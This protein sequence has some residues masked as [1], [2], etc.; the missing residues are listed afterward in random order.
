[1]ATAK[2][3]QPN[4]ALAVD[5]EAVRQAAAALRR[6]GLVVFPTETVY[7]LGAN[8]LDPE[9]VERIYRVKGRPATSPLIV[10]VASVEGAREVVAEWPEKAARLAE[11]FWPGPLTLVLPKKPIVA[12]IVT[13][14]LATVGVRMPDHAVA[15]ALIREAGVPVAAPSANRF[16]QLSPTRVSHLPDSVRAAA[17]WVLDAGPAPLG[18]EST[19]VSL[20]AS[21]PQLLRPGMISKAELEAVIGHVELAGRIENAHPAPGMHP[22]HYAP[23]T[24]LILVTEGKLPRSGRG[25]Y[26]WLRQPAP[27]ARLVRMPPEPAAYAALLYATLHELDREGYDWIAV[28]RPPETVEWAA[29][30]DRLQRA[31]A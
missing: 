7:G 19:V 27:A 8:A 14:G 13:A 23:A 9:A 17:D 26:L 10:H 28:E 30:A 21:P 29:I 1:L 25:A 3:K 11:R 12:D 2:T 20:A 15:L 6:G 22:K 4:K 18:I 31:A 5:L 24:P 16:T